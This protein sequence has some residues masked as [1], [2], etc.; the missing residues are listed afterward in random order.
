MT[1]TKK[2]FVPI[3]PRKGMGGTSSIQEQIITAAESKGLDPALALAVANQE[4]A[5]NPNA[6]SPVGAIGL[7]QLMPETAKGLGVD[8]YNVSDNILGGVTYLTQMLARFGGNVSLAL[9]AYNAGPGAVSKYNGIPPYKE[10]QNYVATITSSLPQFQNLVGSYDNTE[11]SLS[12]DNSTSNDTNIND[13]IKTLSFSD[14][15][16]Y[17]ANSD[18]IN[19]GALAIESLAVGDY[20]VAMEILGSNIALSFSLVG[21]L[22]GILYLI[23]RN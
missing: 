5:F 2:N 3:M 12:V 14:V 1:N 16:D 17:L 13:N 8:P 18:L 20:P 21:G 23:S 15:N 11:S 6:K 9:A 7:F 10:T 22:L 4:S 19:N